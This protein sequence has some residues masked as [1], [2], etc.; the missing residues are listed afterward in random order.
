[1]IS[2]NS[3]R[4]KVMQ[5]IY[6]YHLSSEKSMVAV[7][8]NLTQTFENIYKL[9]L[10]LLSA[11]GALTH[12]AEHIIET[13]KQKLLPTE[14]DLHP[15]YK[16]VN[17]LFVKKIEEST[18][19]KKALRKHHVSWKNDLDML[20]IRKVYHQLSNTPI[21]VEYMQNHEQ[22]FEKDKTFI[23]E[24]I[25]KFLLDNEEIRNYL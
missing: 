6:E 23:I 12:I 7:E 18:A 22:S 5:A 3:I 8:M 13:K 10:Q 9:Y 15:N 16:F 2:R 11:F 21:F 14:T 1:M 25:E 20:F 17:N 19:L 4:I 24:L